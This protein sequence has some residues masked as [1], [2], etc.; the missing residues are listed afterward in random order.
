MNQG[1][2]IIGLC[3]QDC[4]SVANVLMWLDSVRDSKHLK[5]DCPKSE[6]CTQKK[7]VR[8]KC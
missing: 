1:Y 4:R 2:F 8:R 7:H 5:N 6:K 3:V